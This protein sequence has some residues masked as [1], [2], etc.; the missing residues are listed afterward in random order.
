M[1]TVLLLLLLLPSSMVG[2]AVPA[3]SAP[4]PAATADATVFRLAVAGQQQRHA[5]HM[6]TLLFAGLAYLCVCHAVY[7]L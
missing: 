1:T 5:A 3:V 7:L 2:R 6:H 4:A